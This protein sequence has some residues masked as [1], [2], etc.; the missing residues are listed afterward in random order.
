LPSPRHAEERIVALSWSAWTEP[1]VAGSDDRV[2]SSLAASL[3]RLLGVL[4]RAGT[5]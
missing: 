1:A 2:R 4:S 3:E 5:A